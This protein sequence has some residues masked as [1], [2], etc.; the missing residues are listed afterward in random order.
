MRSGSRF[1]KL[2]GRVSNYGGQH[3][4]QGS[5][6][7]RRVLGKVGYGVRTVAFWQHLS[8]AGTVGTHKAGCLSCRSA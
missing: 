8:S 6:A 4:A 5:A 7:S 1:A 2:T 3:S